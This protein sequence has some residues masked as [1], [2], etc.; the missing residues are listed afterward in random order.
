MMQGS[1]TSKKKRAAPQDHGFSDIVFSWSLEDIFNENLFKDKVEKIPDSF[2]SA[3][4]YFR[5]FVFP[6]LEETR[7]QLCSGMDTISRAPFAQVVD[8]EES[9]PY[10]I[11]LYDVK[12][13]YWKNRFSNRGKEPYKM[14]PGDV[15]ILADTKPETA[16]D[17]QKVGNMW[18]F[19]SVTKITEDENE[20]EIG[21]T[22]SHFKVKVS[23][24]IQ[25]DDKKKKSIFVI[26]LTNLI[27]NRRIWNSLHMPGNLKVINEIL[28]TSSVVE[29]KCDC[30]QSKG[31][32]YEKYGPRLSSTLN[33]SQ[34]EAVLAC[35]ARTHC[36]HKCSVELIWGPPGT[37]KTKTVSMLLFRLLNMKCR[38]LV[39]APTNV[40]IMEVASRVLLLVKESFEADSERA[41]LFCPLGDVLLFGNNERLKVDGGT[42]EIYLD[43]RIEKLAE[44]FVRL[45]GWRHCFM[46]MI[47][48]LE[49]CA[50][51]YQIFLENKLIREN[52][53]DDEIIECRNETEGSKG[54]YKSFLDFVRTRFNLIA[55]AL[56]NCLVIFC[57]HVPKEY[58]LEANFHNIVYLI[59]L[60]ESLETLLF[61]DNTASEELEELFSHSVDE[62]FSELIMDEKYLLQKRR[63]ECRSVL[64][65]LCV[66]LNELNLP[67]VMNKE[68]LK[69]FC[70][71]KASLIFCTASSSYK[72][73]SVHMEPLS[74]LV[75]DEA[76]QLRESESTIPLQLPDIKHAILIGDERQL[77]AMVESNVSDKAGF[78][79]SLFERLNTL[80]HSKSKQLLNIQ[81]RMHPAISFFPN[82]QFYH[83]QIL[84]GPNVRQK[85]YEKHYLSGPMFG[86][87]SFI[88]IING[89]E[90]L[91]D[92]GH[93]RKNLVEVSVVLKILQNLY[94]AWIGSNKK[95]SIGVVSPYTA[96]V[97]AIKDK[98][99]HKYE[100]RDGFAVKV[101][102]V[103]G[104]QGGE[105]DIIIISSVRSNTEG[106]IGF[107][108]KPQRINVAL[109]RARHCLWILG[110]DRTLTRSDSVWESLVH[111]AK[112]RR[113]FF[114]ADDDKDL[115]KAILE[116]KKELDEMEELLNPE[117]IL[118]RSQRWKVVFSDNFLQSF[119]KMKSVQTKK[120]VINYLM[121]LASG[122]RPKRRNI[123]SVCGSSSQIV[124]Q[125]KVEGLFVVCTI[126]I[127]KEQRYIQVL[128][129]WDI[130]P[131]EEVSKLM[132]RLDDI[133]VRYTGDYI[134]R[135]KEKCLDGKLEVPKTWAASS[136]ITRLKDLANEHGSDL[137]GADF[138]GRSYVENSKVS[139]SLLLMKF[140]SLSFGIVSH[141]LSDRD[142]RELDLPFEVTD[143]QLEMILFPRST[144]I[145]GRSGTGKTTILTMKVF[146]KE[147]L[148]HMAMEGFYGAES[149]TDPNTS[150]KNEVEEVPGETKRA[151]LRQLFVTVSPKLCFAVKQHISHLK[152]SA[153]GGKFPAE[154]SLIDV[155]DIDDAA[156]FKDI[157]NSF[158]DIPHK[159]FP[160]I[161]TF[162]K[163]L[164]MLDGTLG[165]SYF[166][167]FLNRNK[168]SDG[169]IQSSMSIALQTFIRT[170]E[171]NYDRF[172]SLYWPHFNTE[173]TKRLDSSRVYTEIISHIKGGM[174]AMEVV[175]CKLSREDY[176]QLSDGRVSTLSTHKREKIY[177][178][179]LNYEKMKVESGEFDLADLV[180]DLHQRLK[181]KNC[182]VDEMDFVY[183]DEVQDL[184]M[185]QIGLFKYICKN[186]DEGFVFSGDT[187]QTIAR[188]IDFR[189]QD[190]RA[191]FYKKFVLDSSSNG[192]VRRERKRQLSDVLSLS[193]NF[194]THAG[195]LKL[196][197]SIIELLFRFF[198][199][200]I[201]ILKPETSLIYGEPPVLLESESKEDA[202][203]K[204]FGNSGNFGGNMVGFGA[205]QVILVRD[206]C[207][208][209]EISNQVG[210]QALV[211][212]IVDCKGLEFQDVLLYNF[213]SSS[214]LKNKWRVIYEYMKEQDLL[215]SP[216]PFPSFNEAK[217]NILCSELK[218]LY[219]AI[220]R[221][222]QRLWIWENMEELCKPMFDYWKKKCLVQVRQLDDS[223]A[224][225]MQVASSPE[226]WRSQG[227]KL[228]HEHN[229]EMA[230]MCFERAGDTYW[231]RRTKAT[232]LKASADR[233]CSSNPEE[234]NII[235]REAAEIFEAIGKADSAARCFFDLGEYERAGRIYLEK[236]EES[237]LERAA[238]CFYLAGCYEQ[239]AEVYAKGNFFSECLNVCSKGKLFELGLQ[240]I[241]YWKQHA[242]TD[243]AVVRRTEDLYKIEQGFLESCALHFHELQDSKSMMKF[244][245]TFHSM[246]LK[247]SFLKSQNCLDELLLL[248]EE[249]GNF[250]D[251]ASIAKLRGD[252]LLAADLLQKAGNFKEASTLTLNYVFSNSLWS[253]G[254]KG[255]PLK[256]FSQKE[257]L[258]EKAKCLAK[259]EPNQFYEFVFTEAEILSNH[260]ANLPRLNQLLNAS[261]RHKS[262]KGEILSTR[263]ILDVH[264]HSNISKYEW[265]D[266]FVWNP[267][268]KICKNKES[269]ETLVYFWNY[270]KDKTL[271]IFE[272][273]GRLQT[274]DDNDYRG[275]G[276]FCLNY[277]GVCKQCESWGSLDTIY[278]LLNCD[279]DWVREWDAG[280]AQGSGKLVSIDVRQ[281][282]SAGR[283]YWSSELLSV[284][285]KVLHNLEA[286]YT[287][288]RKSSL[289]I[290][291]QFRS[292]TY[293]Y[294]V[295][296]FLS[297]FKFPDHRH[298][299]A[300]TLQKF[301]ELSTEHFFCYMFPLD[302]QE[303]LRENLFSLRRTEVCRSML[304]EVIFK[305]T[306]LKSKLSYGQI[307]RLAVMTL[308]S[309]RLHHELYQQVVKRCA[310]NS[311]WKAFLENFPANM[312]LE[313]QQ[314]STPCIKSKVSL[315]QKFHGALL[316][317]YNANW[318]L[319][320][321]ISPACF[322]YLIE[323][324][325]IMLS[326]IQGYII[327]TESSFV[328]WLTHQEG[329]SN[330]TYLVADVRHSLGYVL[331]SLINIVRQL[332]F[333]QM[334][335][336][337]WV[338]RCST[339]PMDYSLVVLR[340]VVIACLIHLNFGSCGN[341]LFEL[342]GSGF[343]TNKLPREFYDVLRRGWKHN[344]S[345]VNVNLLANA[346]KTIGNPLVIV[347]LGKDC[348]QFK[349]PGTIFVDMKVSQCNDILRMFFPRF[350]DSEVHAG[351]TELK[352]LPPDFCDEGNNSNI[353]SSNS[354]SPLDLDFIV[355]GKISEGNVM[356]NLGLFWK[357]VGVLNLVEHEKYH[358]SIELNAPTIKV[359]VEIIVQH[360]CIAMD[361]SENEN[362]SLFEE[363]TSMVE[364][365]RQLYAALDVSELE[366]KK[367]VSTIGE[368]FKRL[369][370]RRATMEP[371][372]NKLLIASAGKC[373]E[374][375]NDNK[376]AE[377]SDADDKGNAGASSSIGASGNK[378]RGKNKSKRKP[379]KKKGQ[380]H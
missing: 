243:V 166:E 134:N 330:Q 165:T 86:P 161:I 267:E 281:L 148:H 223:L 266:E 271:N 336:M 208:R 69:D 12:V 37:G 329:N 127:V 305:C 142:G 105:E 72:L 232:G 159:S 68:S 160:L 107:L 39:C 375:N 76:A 30:V 35:L 357:M 162:H 138:D 352:E 297:D 280:C 286:L 245:R 308:G 6:L 261:K 45:T 18:T 65:T 236:Y 22:S 244:V 359:I 93:S 25:I 175:D 173:L 241:H 294:V 346:F 178:I 351:T 1:G 109:T 23:K 71:E 361:F 118:F 169:Q 7:A 215:E 372:L 98:L 95:L 33:D 128:K 321:Y 368:L 117:S 219:V 324:L 365:L 307:G 156:E 157:P 116:V 353:T 26:F 119:K 270:W 222:R 43:H 180:I 125:F 131:L 46:S 233:L 217:H 204:I 309:G 220:T 302:W 278:I 92:V 59:S 197:Q 380:K 249:S 322:L 27:P 143:E 63:S 284:G 10:G 179:F 253:H 121:K 153:F 89:R 11:G 44:C 364:E 94:K 304:A 41:D 325:L 300:K 206:D 147:K 67:V 186:V 226:E 231:E 334:D 55:T 228:F 360:Q 164:M 152:S 342:L 354:A 53:N 106:S 90:E 32:C 279:A 235:L 74:L 276:D 319:Y 101:Q 371:F 255:W 130:L 163:F 344:F 358:M 52:S 363:A 34:V 9:K 100:S 379:K 295:A 54:E 47:D 272:C 70:F 256:Q 99:G 362:G 108:S 203:I 333:N 62:E 289:P 331:E 170:K 213:F 264:L 122:W 167:R 316:D 247:R 15:L 374:E 20:S 82:S 42:E 257:E 274:Q 291:C 263:M 355:D 269:I 327:T 17:L 323:R 4:E 283:S 238:E 227:I 317:T 248:E 337:D 246:D 21:S 136:D 168:P 188:G 326:S 16:S 96:Q 343:I 133:F 154:S 79:R 139:E 378:S 273:L 202:I 38:T 88:S 77:P 318:R 60:L 252:I 132:K 313:S 113:C 57:T 146:Q 239:A 183:V 288:S 229:Y 225:A 200:S 145:H 367:N 303:Q 194:R 195:V 155:D 28:Y 104:F 2:R 201:D 311:P 31:I 87:Y 254:S 338:R 191:L 144:F 369:Q 141:L 259:M 187:A 258:L 51:Q 349:S 172:C 356:M 314:G 91:D 3:G 234:A 129:V 212:T 66:S 115:A 335:T 177:D 190:I 97:V 265:E 111:D 13:D 315:V 85:S 299:A 285:M 237:E 296:K 348:S 290:F 221:T 370:S 75:I 56:R 176:V 83:N 50:S 184:T 350:D 209:K 19:L 268:Y 158:V 250:L 120:S 174:H 185:S 14:L 182:Q 102:S 366:L 40:A 310:G 64:K 151:I 287:H 140:Y 181:N 196:A 81:Y 301:L 126:D 240:C 49:E 260:Q 5:T 210:K 345:N 8:L 137:S 292:L 340:L 193:Q 216:M 150:Q 376:A 199:Q 78:G 149:R 306:G 58:I 73:H 312:G 242:N 61:Q 171:V 373:D 277:L 262:L 24:D 124:K 110:N 293:I 320:D 214:N 251:A 48:F 377:C 207:A 135:C 114:N 332:L 80:G 205:Q 189:F 275:Y 224:Q 347:S 198:P 230:T 192:D 282:V 103:D 36:H 328:D 84:D 298:H 211:L 339:N 218:Q 123:D 341:T 112:E 29:E